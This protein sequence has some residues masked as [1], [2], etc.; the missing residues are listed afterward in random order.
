MSG[1][2]GDAPDD[3]RP[4]DPRDLERV[5]AAA[6]APGV[7]LV[8][9]A[10]LG[11]VVLGLL[12]GPLVF[13]PDA[14]VAFFKGQVAKQPP[15]PERQELEQKVAEFEAALNQDRDGY[16]RQNALLLG[17]GAALDLLA[18][19]GG[20]ALARVSGYRLAM[21]GTLVSLVPFA[22]GCCVTGIPFGLWGLIVLARPETKAAFAARRTAG[23]PA[24]PDA[25][26]L[27]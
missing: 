20:V 22:T 21:A 16:V 13:D 17:G 26:Y 12:S 5:R 9:N 11:L 3:P 27:R 14:M 8:V 25:H 7:F 10:L 2:P 6:Q 1:Y 4:A 18:A 23:P 15:G 24:D 19:A